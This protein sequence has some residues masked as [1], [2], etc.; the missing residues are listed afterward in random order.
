MP[1][2][3]NIDSRPIAAKQVINVLLGDKN[4][5]Y[6][7][8]GIDQT[9]LS[10]TDFSHNGLRK[11]LRDR[12]AAT[13]KMYIIIKA[14]A[15]SRYKNMIDVLDEMLIGEYARYSIVKITPEE[16]ALIAKAQ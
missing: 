8:T 14:A 9:S 15:A 3:D 2:T 7:Y 11:I 4:K 13:P 6:W 5:V 10:V 16:E 12:K 1:P